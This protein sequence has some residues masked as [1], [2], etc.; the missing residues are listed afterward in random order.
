[1][2]AST[3][4]PPAAEHAPKQQQRCCCMWV[5][6]TLVHARPDAC[7]ESC[8]R[9]SLLTVVHRVGCN[10]EGQQAGGC[11]SDTPCTTAQHSTMQH[12]KRRLWSDLLTTCAAQL[13]VL[14]DNYCWDCCLMA[15]ADLCAPDQ[16]PTAAGVTGCSPTLNG[17]CDRC[18]PQTP[19]AVAN[20]ASCRPQL[21][22]L[23]LLTKGHV[24]QPVP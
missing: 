5:G 13:R 17:W 23:L 6:A 9:V 4:V 21:Q 15:T 12:G 7:P 18:W 16:S 11:A 10:K 3:T 14:L 1:M 8:M 22:L 2:R 20:A 19:T 24:I